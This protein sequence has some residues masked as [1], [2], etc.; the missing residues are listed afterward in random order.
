[1]SIE[2]PV[3]GQHPESQPPTK[4]DPV[5][6]LAVA[7][8]CATTAAYFTDWETAFSVFVAIVSLF[9]SKRNE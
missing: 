7:A 2:Q 8:V 9:T 3:G 4:P 5:V 6:V 1:M